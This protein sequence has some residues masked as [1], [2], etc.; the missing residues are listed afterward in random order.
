VWQNKRTAIAEEV[1]GLG[2]MRAGLL[3]C[4]KDTYAAR[5]EEGETGSSIG[6]GKMVVDYE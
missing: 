6:Q 3:K 4:L 2:V 1:D 5:Q